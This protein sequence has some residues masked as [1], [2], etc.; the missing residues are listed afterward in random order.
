MWN[1][2]LNTALVEEMGFTRIAADHCVYIHT[3]EKGTSI[4]AIPV[5]DICAAT[6]TKAEMENVKTDIGVI[7][8]LV[9]LG[10]V[11]HL[12]GMAIRRDH[13]SRTISLSQ[14]TYIEMITKRLNLM[15][16]YVKYTPLD[17]NVVLSKDLLRTGLHGNPMQNQDVASA[18]EGCKKLFHGSS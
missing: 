1:S 7:F 6:S 4:L 8:D 14:C 13:A 17:P 18:S 15:N 9:D 2:H 5:D 10:E 12:L 3:T 16:A 11:H